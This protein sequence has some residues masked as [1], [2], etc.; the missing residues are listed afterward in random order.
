MGNFPY[1]HPVLATPA[2]GKPAG[3]D[4]TL[5]QA[6]MLDPTDRQALYQ[7]G[8]LAHERGDPD[9]AAQRFSWT[10]RLYSDHAL[11]HHGLCELRRLRSRLDEA[12]AHGR[13]AV[14]LEPGNPDFHYNL[15]IAL[16][17]RQ[18]IEEAIACERRAVRLAPDAPEP[19]F[20]LAENLLIAGRLDEGWQ[21]YEWRYRLPHAPPPIPVEWL[22]GRGLA[23]CPQWNGQ[24][25]EGTL[26]LVADQGF[27][28]VIQ[29]A[30]YVPM[31]AT[32]CP[33]AIVACSA[34]MLPI[35]RQQPGGLNARGLWDAVP[36]FD[37]WCPLSGL[38]RLFGT[39]LTTIPVQIPYLHPDPELAA[40]WRTR[41]DELVPKGLRRVGLVW[42]GRSTHGNDHN[43]SMRLR[44]LAALFDLKTVALVSLQLGPAQAEIGRYFGKTPLVNLGPEI[45]DFDDTMAILHGLER[46]VSVDTAVAHLGGAMGLPT[47]ILL[48]FAPDWRWQLERSDTPW[49]PTVTLHRQ[50][51]P[52]RWEEPVQEVCGVLSRE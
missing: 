11:A 15:G 43:R 48:P 28:D 35:L 36:H 34:E 17:D 8:V 44:Q 23:D 33:N 22:T 51:S 32:L 9:C 29:F 45:E 5:L 3:T 47:S 16:H 4:Y 24:P 27:G 20:E 52:G 18:D 40:R 46:L 13:H 26:L 38:P 42:S 10:I 39:V 2:T 50:I 12:V 37:A 41:L 19:H 30:R 25:M 31:A 49:Y 21:E 14:A 1:T 7:A 6:L